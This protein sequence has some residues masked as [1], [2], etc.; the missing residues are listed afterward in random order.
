MQVIASERTPLWRMLPRVIG[1]NMIFIAGKPRE[2]L[3]DS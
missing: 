1:S 3:L 2:A